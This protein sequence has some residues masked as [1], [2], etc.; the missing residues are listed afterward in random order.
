MIPT[1]VFTT[2]GA[3]IGAS[4]HSVIPCFL[5]RFKLHTS[6]NPNKDL[7]LQTHYGTRL[8][9]NQRLIGRSLYADIAPSL[10]ANDAY[11]ALGYVLGNS[12]I[13]FPSKPKSKHPGTRI[14]PQCL[15][16]G[17]GRAIIRSGSPPPIPSALLSLGRTD[18]RDRTSKHPA[19]APHLDYDTPPT[20]PEGIPLL[21]YTRMDF[22]QVVP[23]PTSS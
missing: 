13:T 2:P 4:I 6:T 17:P 11:F 8:I 5:Y 14:Q 10:E 15:S 12:I 7:P 20:L 1:D 19:D 23:V 16:Q 3:I 18:R 22:T 9:P 21:D